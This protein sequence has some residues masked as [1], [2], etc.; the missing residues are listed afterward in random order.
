MNR[1]AGFFLVAH[2]TVP[3]RAR[4]SIRVSWNEQERVSVASGRSRESSDC[5]VDFQDE[6]TNLIR[7]I[8]GD[9]EFRGSSFRATGSVSECSSPRVAAATTAERHRY[10]LIPGRIRL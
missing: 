2:T 8:S 1:P 10:P 9:Q 5:R 6:C 4:I 3:E 7:F